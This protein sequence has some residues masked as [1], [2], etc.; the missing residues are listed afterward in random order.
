MYALKRWLDLLVRAITRAPRIQLT[1]A[2]QPDI[3]VRR[4]LELSLLGRLPPELIIYT[5]RFLPPD[6]AA[7]F[8]FCCYSIYNILG[9]RYW[10][11][12]QTQDPQLLIAFLTLL[13]RDRPQY[14]VCSPCR[15]LHLPYK[16]TRQAWITQRTQ[17]F[18]SLGAPCSL[19]HCA[20][21]VCEYIHF[22]FKFTNFQM[23]MKRY[24]LGL[25]YDDYFSSLGCDWVDVFRPFIYAAHAK[26]IAGSLIL[27]IQYRFLIPISQTLGVPSSGFLGICPHTK[28]S[29]LR[30][31]E[32]K[33]ARCK[34]KHNHSI[35]QCTK[36]IK[37]KQCCWCL[38]EYQVDLQECGQRGSLIAIT[39]WLDL[40]EG[41]NWTDVKWK[42]HLAD[43]GSSLYMA[44]HQLETVDREETHLYKVG[45]IRDSFEQN[46]P[47]GFNPFP[48]QQNIEES[49]ELLE[50]RRR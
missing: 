15:K 8:A 37:L 34:V 17:I 44:P 36:R 4:G 42:S 27:R 45:C 25:P 6:A 5:T 47:G 7:S 19:M 13:E 1:P 28:T 48:S 26:I 9:T 3:R 46:K 35:W 14:I 29:S 11:S 10:E 38:T 50:R 24:R 32:L 16:E 30:L 31:H 18:S 20:G 39:K 2:P 33:E 41:R 22:Q 21:R 43:R 23:A 40:G 49:L 12:L